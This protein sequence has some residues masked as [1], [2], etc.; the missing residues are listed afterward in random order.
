MPGKSKSTKATT[1]TLAAVFTVSV[2]GYFMGMRQTV[3]ETQHSHTPVDSH[4]TEVELHST[5]QQAVDYRHIAQA[6]FGP[7]HNFKSQL[8]SLQSNFGE[9]GDPH[10]LLLSAESLR[11]KRDARRAYDGA[12]PTVPHP[13]S[14][15]NSATCLQC[16]STAT[17]IGDVIAPAISHPEYTSCTQ[18]HVSSKGLGSRWNTS[19]FD[20]HTG[21]Q[22]VGNTAPASKEQAYADAPMTIPHTVHMRQNC[23]SCHGEY[24]TSPIRTSHPER[25]SCTQCHVPGAQIDKRNFAESPFPFRAELNKPPHNTPQASNP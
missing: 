24:G 1:L 17:Q 6:G 15:D 3:R 5:I 8:S 4:T 21:N 9:R 2:S 19:N 14:Q 16:H 23:M 18:C 10:P 13:I 11:A 22:F 25:Q 7:N 12:P 20:L